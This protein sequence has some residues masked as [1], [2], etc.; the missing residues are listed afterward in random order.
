MK[1][2]IKCENCNSE[3]DFYKMNCDSCGALLRDKFPNIDLFS[4]I[5]LLIETPTNGFKKIIFAEHKNYQLF[6]LILLVTKL[7]F[8]SFFLQSVFVEPVNCQNYLSVNFGISFSTLALLTLLIPFLLKILLSN[9]SVITRYKD[10]LAITIYSHFP[11]VLFLLVVLP[12]EIAIFGKFWIFS[13]PSPFMIKETAAYLFSF[14]EILTFIWTFILFGI[15]IKIQSNS[16]SFAFVI[17]LIYASIL[18]ALFF[19]IPYLG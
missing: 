9:N 5:W 12:V 8:T 1:N 3:S 13:N 16:K 6:L 11:L 14:L 2:K 19:L 18:I 15:S 17:T 4:T 10:N 7:V